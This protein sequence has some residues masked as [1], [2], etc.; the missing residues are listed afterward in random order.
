MHVKHNGGLVTIWYR[1]QIWFSLLA[2]RHA[3]CRLFT[4][5]WKKTKHTSIYKQFDIV[6]L[7]QV[8]KPFLVEDS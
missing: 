8:L 3:A 7:F 1:M 4:Y 6:F 2:E 5:L